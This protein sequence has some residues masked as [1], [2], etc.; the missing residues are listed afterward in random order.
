MRVLAIS[1]SLRT[2]SSNPELLRAA[3]LLAMPPM[4]VTLYEG[5]DV[6]SL[7]RAGC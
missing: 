7:F 4:L 3:A 2:G 5:F 1:G 6:T